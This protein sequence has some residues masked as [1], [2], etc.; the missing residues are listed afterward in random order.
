M[1][2]GWTIALLLIGAYLVGGIPF[3]LLVAR[4]RGV[5]IRRH[6]S[7]NV[8]A[9]NVGRVLGR[10]W[11]AIVFLLDAGKGMICTLAAGWLG[12]ASETNDPTGRLAA[13]D[14]LWLGAGLSCVLGSV[15]PVYLRFRGG[16]GVAA[17]IGALLGIYPYL[18]LPALVVLVAWAVVA[19]TSGYVS[20]GSMVAAALLPAVFMVACRLF[21]WPVAGHYPLLGL[22]LALAALV[23]IRHRQNIGRLMAG[24]ENRIGAVRSE[25]QA[26]AETDRAAFSE[27]PSPRRPSP[28]T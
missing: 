12:H 17:S 10:K 28:P 8:G 26:A 23:L 16:K 21:N 25:S 20:L 11:G 6:G 22:C 14:W 4:L 15:A 2:A 19:R 9:T 18:T 7:G 27:S 13:Q 1:T 24:T 5:D 3:G